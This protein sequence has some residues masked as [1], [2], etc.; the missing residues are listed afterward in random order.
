MTSQQSRPMTDVP[1]PNPTS[2]LH[3]FDSPAFLQAM[4]A[5]APNA[6]LKAVLECMNKAPQRS[7][8]WFKRYVTDL[9]RVLPCL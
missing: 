4:C 9:H 2:G 6:V 8:A 5:G 7:D 1:P 3:E